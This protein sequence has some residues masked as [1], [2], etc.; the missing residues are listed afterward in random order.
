MFNRIKMM[1][2][3]VLM[4]ATSAA[5]LEIGGLTIPDTLDS[6][7]GE[8]ILNG[9]GLRKKF[10]FKVYAGSLYL[11]ARTSDSKAIIDADEPMAIT[12][13]WKRNGPRDKIIQVWDEAFTYAGG[14][15]GAADIA[16]FKALTVDGEKDKV[17]KYLYLPGE[18][19]TCWVD[20]NLIET[21][22]D[23]N[24][25]KALFSVWLLES[26]TFTGDKEL[27]DGMLGK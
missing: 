13:T 9:S 26:D 6:G 11:K 10:G 24:F 1:V 4:T 7:K 5:A 14:D 18:G 17:W 25:K 8:L 12:M 3:I 23:F 21:F 15:A 22:T 2:L 19:L 20:G 16:R 27:R